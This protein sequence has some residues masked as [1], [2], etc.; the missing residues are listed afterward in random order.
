MS[1]I[2]PFSFDQHAV[3]T[4]EQN[5][6]V[7]FIAGD[8]AAAL[9]YRMASDM[10]RSLDDDEKGTQIVRTPSGDQEILIINE[11]G[12]YSAI[13]RSRKPEA[14]RFKKWVTAEVLPAIRKTGRYLPPELRFHDFTY[15]DKPLR[16]T[17]EG[18]GIWLNAGDLTQA[19]GIVEPYKAYERLPSF[20]IKPMQ[21]RKA[22]LRM[23]HIDA[24]EHVYLKA[25]AERVGPFRHFL[26]QLLATY[27]F[28]DAPSTD[29]NTLAQARQTALSYWQECEL[30]MKQGNVAMPALPVDQSTLAMG[31]LTQMLTEQ[32]F[33]LQFDSHLTPT[34]V[35]LQQDAEI[36][37]VSDARAMGRLIGERINRKVLTEVMRVGI[38]RLACEVSGAVM[39]SAAGTHRS[40]YA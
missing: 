39:P 38:D 8:V 31:L 1:N 3:R 36:V 40:D 29:I 27:H 17:V 16:I 6:Q 25:D 19:L 7:W 12:L 26:A 32:R 18:K 13:L 34:L 15:H 33:L 21:H 37:Q 20:H 14:K 10:T 4:I 22:Q 30:A 11:S 28:T 9:E 5:G 23:V 24:L 35:P 2:I